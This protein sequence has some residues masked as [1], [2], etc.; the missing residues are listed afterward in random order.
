MRGQLPTML[1]YMALCR[2]LAGILEILAAFLML[3]S[4]KIISA[5]KI[6]ALLG[7]IGPI[8]L[9]VTNV[10]GLAAVRSDLPLHKIFI[11]AL[12]VAL[13]FWGTTG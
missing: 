7:L 9:L 3:H 6:N 12:G 13:V 11:I 1:Y 5:L 8:V 10:F 2:F 4:G